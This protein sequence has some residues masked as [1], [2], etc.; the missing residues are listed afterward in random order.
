MNATVRAGEPAGELTVEVADVI[1]TSARQ[2]TRL[3][4]AVRAFDDP[5][6]FRVSRGAQDRAHPERPAE[7]LELAGQDLTAVTPLTNAALLVPHRVARNG[8]E[9]AEDLEHAAQHVMPS[10]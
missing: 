9:L 1:E 10:T 8:A 4:I 6:R 2:E 5:F 7:R 3:E